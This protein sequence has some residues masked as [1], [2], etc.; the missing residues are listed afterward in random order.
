MNSI[1]VSTNQ[2][3]LRDTVTHKVNR[4]QTEMTLQ[5]VSDISTSVSFFIYIYMH[6]LVERQG[7]NV[8]IVPQLSESALSSLH[9]CVQYAQSSDYD[10]ALLV[11]TSLA[12]GADFAAVASFLPGLK[13]LFQMAAQ[14]QVYAR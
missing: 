14:L 10:N 8:T 13:S 11:T 6:H 3:T 4:T 1:V 12:N 7:L 5:T 9:T 2:Y